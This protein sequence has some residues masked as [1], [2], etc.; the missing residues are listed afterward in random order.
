[1]LL[2]DP[3]TS[4]GLLLAV[5]KSAIAAFLARAQE[6]NQPAWVIGE[7]VIGLGVEVL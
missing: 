2:F 4:G 1:M 6:I 5:P 7:V 3:Q